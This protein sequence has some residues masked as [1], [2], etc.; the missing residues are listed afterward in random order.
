MRQWL[1]QNSFLAV[2]LSAILPPPSPFKLFVIASGVVEM[3]MWP[4][5]MALLAGRGFRYLGIGFLA[6][7]YGRAAE[8]YLFEHK[9][10]LAA[11]GLGFI[12]LS[13]LVTR[14]AFRK[15][16]APAQS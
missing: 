15:P 4:F 10:I 13:Y 8:H 3:E 2:A 9:L 6:V 1:S 12:L 14:L 5:S 11:A 16:H 7:R